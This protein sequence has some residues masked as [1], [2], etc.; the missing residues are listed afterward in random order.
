MKKALKNVELGVRRFLLSSLRVL[1]RRRQA[2]PPDLDFNQ[3]KI[4]FIRQDR[5]GDVLISTP[6]FAA[7]KNH[8]PGITIDVFLSRNNNF[9]LAND[10]EIRKRWV[11]TKRIGAVLRTLKRI[12]SERYDFVVD[13]MDNPSATS[14]VLML[15]AKGTWNVGLQKENAYACDIV[16]PLRS[17]KDSHIVERIAQLL[18]VFGI[19]PGG[20]D[21][22]IRYRTSPESDRQ[23]ETFL[24]ETGKHS[25][26]LIGVN[27]SAGSDTRFWG[28]RNYRELVRWLS[29]R[30]PS[31][32]VVILSKPEDKERVKG[33]LEGNPAAVM[34][35]ETSFDSFAAWIRQLSVLISPDTSAV[36]LAAAFHVPSVILYVQSNTDLRIWEPYN[37]VCEPLV[38]RVDDL[39]TISLRDVTAAVDRLVSRTDLIPART[40]EVTRRQRA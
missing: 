30:F 16:V 9:V 5:I 20:E 17:R 40:R 31:S 8:Y 19:D 28:V 29:E 11:Y 10:Q 24:T 12:R 21:L 18:S 14:T 36:H 34:V 27:I 3:C 33:I 26:S 13:L 2:L 7:L 1:A 15:L 35:P 39:T 6:I 32:C 23:V 22:Q 4:L 25:V 37:T 38:T